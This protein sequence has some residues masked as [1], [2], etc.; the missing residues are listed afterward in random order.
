M[1]KKQYIVPETEKILL[2]LTD[3]VLVV[4]DLFTGSASEEN[5][6]GWGGAKENDDF[7]E[8]EENSDLGLAP[9][10]PNIWGDDEEE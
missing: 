2:K 9:T 3:P 10:N 5:H 6:S 7:E 1:K 8:V 4:G